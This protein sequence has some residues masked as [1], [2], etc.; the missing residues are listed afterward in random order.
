M[1]RYA[2]ILAAVVPVAVSRKS[3]APP[4]PR[5]GSHLGREPGRGLKLTV[6]TITELCAW[7]FFESLEV[8]CPVRSCA[9]LFFLAC[10]WFEA[11]VF[12]YTPPRPPP[13]AALR[14]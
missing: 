1:L 8:S 13:L 3:G 11:A 9:P 7:G 12:P 4:R 2:H 5:F 6:I 10:L 14:W